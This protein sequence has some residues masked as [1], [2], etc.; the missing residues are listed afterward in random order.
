MEQTNGIIKPVRRWRK[1][2]SKEKL[3]LRPS[4][5]GDSK[6]VSA[7]GSQKKLDADN[8]SEKSISESLLDE[9]TRAQIDRLSDDSDYDCD[10]DLEHIWT[11]IRKKGESWPHVTESEFHLIGDNMRRDIWDYIRERPNVP[12]PFIKVANLCQKFTKFTFTM[13]TKKAHLTYSIWAEFMRILFWFCYYLC[14]SWRFAIKN[15]H[16]GMLKSDEWVSWAY[17]DREINLLYTQVDPDPDTG[18]N[19]QL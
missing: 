11:V 12:L 19:E 4:A 6:K 9:E 17:N 13:V 3:S 10:S 2:V 8:R 18:K 14:F 15:T 16:V 7:A 5:R 1:R